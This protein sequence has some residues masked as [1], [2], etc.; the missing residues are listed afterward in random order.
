[1]EITSWEKCCGCSACYSV[2]PQKCISMKADANGF[3][4]PSIDESNCISCGK[5]ERTCPANHAN[6]STNTPKSFAFKCN[7]R[8]LTKESSSGG[9]FSLLSETIIKQGG[10][11][12]G[13]CYDGDLSVAHQVISKISDIR[14]LRGSKYVQSNI[15][16]TYIQTLELLKRGIPVLYTGTPCQIAGLKRMLGKTY[17]NLICVEI[18]CHGVP[19]PKVYHTYISYL[20]KKYKSN[21]RGINFRDKK[22]GWTNYSVTINLENN[23]TISILGRHNEYIRG[24]IHN[25]YNRESCANC[26]YK[27]GASE[28]DITIGDLWGAN[29]I[30]G[31]EFTADNSGVSFVSV[32]TE[33]GDKFFTSALKNSARDYQLK[34]IITD[35]AIQYNPSIA[36]AAPMNPHRNNFLSQIQEDSDFSG[37]IDAYLGKIRKPSILSR[38]KGLLYQIYAGRRRSK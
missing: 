14:Q 11:V 3:L 1:M 33:I 9:V 37:L 4:R 7:D 15:A 28:A 38:I 34:E 12:I 2:C 17:E 36:K 25:L 31:E 16:D 5:C 32:S 21:V 22:N 24:F 20:S 35:Q 26:R 30:V 18:V 29:Q 27:L 19:S 13:A 23:K 10:R 6:S 8:Q